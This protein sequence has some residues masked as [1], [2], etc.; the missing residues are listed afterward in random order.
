MFFEMNKN[1]KKIFYYKD[2]TCIS[3]LFEEM[4][5]FVSVRTSARKKTRLKILEKLSLILIYFPSEKNL[6]DSLKFK[7]VSVLETINAFLNLRI[8]EER[9]HKINFGAIS[10]E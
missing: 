9:G 10:Y 8:S 3:L 7:K 4:K 2:S 6:N 1:G 5:I